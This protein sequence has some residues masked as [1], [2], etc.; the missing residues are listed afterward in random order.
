MTDRHDNSLLHRFALATG[1][2]ALLPIALGAVVTTMEAGMAFPDWPSSDG[3]NMLLYP[4]LASAGNRFI[5]HGHRLAGILIGIFSMVLTIIAW[6]TEHR[7]WVRG[8]AMAILCGVVGQGVLGGMRVLRNSDSLALVHGQFAAWVFA[9]I[10]VLILV[11][12]RRWNQ[13]QLRA[14]GFP[15]RSAAPLAIATLAAIVLQYTLGGMVRHL[16]TGLHEHLAA[17]AIVVV[18]VLATFVA[19]CRAQDSWLKAS[20]GTILLFTALQIVLGPATWVT[21]FGFATIGFVATQHSTLQV[22]I[23]TLHTIVGM[24][25]LTGGVLHLTRVSR[26]AWLTGDATLSTNSAL[27]LTARGGVG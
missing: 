12:G 23:R 9:L 8:L 22:T 10:A 14:Q 27:G 15:A 17:A 11:T 1:V 2:V 18:L 24:L 7:L 26:V 3:H 25:V 16:G 6:K 4:W 21:K 20:A 13:R 5:E 19:S